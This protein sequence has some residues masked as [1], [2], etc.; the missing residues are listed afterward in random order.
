VSEA[1]E[2]SDYGSPY[3][4]PPEDDPELA[5]SYGPEDDPGEDDT[6]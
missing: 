2:Y 3:D 6:T 5:E 1:T 4:W